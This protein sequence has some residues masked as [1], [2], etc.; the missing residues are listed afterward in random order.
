MSRPSAVRRPEPAA[1]PGSEDFARS[2]SY[3]LGAIANMLAVGGSRL[4]RRAFKIGLGEWRLMWVLAIAPRITA[5]RAS[6]IIG[7][8]EAAVSRALS[9]LERRGLVRA[10][11]DPSDRRQRIIELSQAGRELHSRILVVAQERERRLLASFTKDEIRL[12]RSL[13]RRL[14]AHA[15]AANAFDPEALLAAADRRRPRGRPIAFD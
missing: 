5:R 3:L 12:L 14:H 8:D 9:G 11:T 1:L 13:L 10:A 6:Q 2:I 7:L 15:A 4:Y